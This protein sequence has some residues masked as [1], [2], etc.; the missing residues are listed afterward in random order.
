[1]SE[2]IGDWLQTFTG[3]QFYP[4]DP[5][6]EDVDIRDIAHALSLV[7]RFGGHVKE[8]YS[9][10]QHSVIVSEI[11][12]DH[13]ALEGLLHDAAEA[14]I[15]DMVRPLK[16]AMPAYK[17]VEI[18]IEKVIADRFGLAFPFPGEIK[19]ADLRACITEKRDM[20]NVQRPGRQIAVPL[21]ETIVPWP[22][23]FAETT[24]LCRFT[25]L[26]SRRTHRM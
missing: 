3:K 5:R 7:C 18:G 16:E 25:E 8:L 2:R 17:E 23:A 9:V 24:F 4:R 20:H 15:G 26:S 21:S 10:A 12:P 11:V 13:L 22:S 14:Y 6:V 19:A 1:M